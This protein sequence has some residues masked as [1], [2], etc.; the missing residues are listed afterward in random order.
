MQV[1]VEPIKNGEINLFPKSLIEEVAQNVG[2]IIASSKF[3]VP[4]DRGFGTSHS[5]VDTPANLAQPRL[6]M[7]V[8][9]AVEKYEPRAEIISIDIK[10]DEAQEGKI[11]PVVEMGVKDDEE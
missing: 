1:L 8:I 10:Q 2:I 3:S 6:V 9:D 5:Q 11:I 4:L 7:E